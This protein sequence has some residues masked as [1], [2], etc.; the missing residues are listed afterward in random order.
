MLFF[1]ILGVF[2]NC[3]R[4]REIMSC[5][6]QRFALHIF[7]DERMVHCFAFLFE[8]NSFKS[9]SWVTNKKTHF[10]EWH[11]NPWGLAHCRAG[12]SNSVQNNIIEE[13]MKFPL[14]L[15]GWMYCRTFCNPTITPQRD[16][17]KCS[18]GS[19][20]LVQTLPCKFS[21]PVKP[22]IFWNPAEKQWWCKLCANISVMCV[23]GEMTS[24]IQGDCPN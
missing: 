4:L 15:S 2:N 20:I 17:T 7:V 1:R 22:H 9:K 11:H 13:P 8:L 6:V 19:N 5:C 23:V 24:I 12:E 21:L 14:I 18:K 10:L 3:Q 16:P